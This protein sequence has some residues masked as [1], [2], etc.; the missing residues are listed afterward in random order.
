MAKLEKKPTSSTVGLRDVVVAFMVSDDSDSTV[1]ETDIQPLAGAIEA[2]ITPENT[3]PEVQ[4]ADDG[5]FDAVYPSPHGT[6]AVNLV[7]IPIALRPRILG[8][9]IDVNG[10]YVNGVNDQQP[11]FA[12]GFKAQ[13]AD[14][15]D[16]YMWMYKVRARPMTEN[17]ATRGTT[18]VTR[19]QAQVTLDYM[20]RQSD[21]NW[22]GMSDVGQNGFTESKAATFFDTVYT[23]G[24]A[25]N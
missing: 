2:V 19:Q 17:Y 16:R 13:K 4:E 11:Y 3:D 6:I 8:G 5:E 18:S 20:T 15:T 9:F 1:Y 22:R 14:G 23:P 21:G 12:L 10:V 7:D 25:S 24:A